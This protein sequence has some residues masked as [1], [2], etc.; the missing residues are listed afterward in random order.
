MLVSIITTTYNSAAT[1]RNTI[2]SVLG[3]THKDIDYWIIDGGSHDGTIDIVREYEP[4][5]N[6]RLHWISEPDKG[7]YDAMNKGINHAV[8]DVVGFLNSDDFYTSPN[9][10]SNLV[11]AFTPDIDAVYGDI[12]FVDDDLV[13]TVRYYSSAAFRPSLLRWGYMPAHPSFYLRRELYHRYGGYS[14]NYKIA[15]DFDMMVRLFHKHKIRAKY[16]PQDFVTMRTGGVSTANIR[17]RILVTHEDAKA[18]R[19]NG[20]FSCFP[21]CCVKYLTKVFEFSGLKQIK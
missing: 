15:S 10:V 7:I 20:L 21:M 18:C 19:V 16:I 17:N 1:V 8:G 4:L 2:E 11:S 9:V 13:T 5:F 6:G 14:I 3:Q 12:H